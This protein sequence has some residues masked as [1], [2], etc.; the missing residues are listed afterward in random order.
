MYVITFFLLAATCG[1]PLQHVPHINNS[2]MILFGYNFQARVGTVI[3]FS[4]LDSKLVLIGPNSSTCM[5]NGEWEPDPREIECK[6][7]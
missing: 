3:S 2:D 1:Y 6:G 4:C 5:G 7:I